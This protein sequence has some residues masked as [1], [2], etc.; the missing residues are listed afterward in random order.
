MRAPLSSCQVLEKETEGECF[1]G[2]E[3][4]WGWEETTLGRETDV[5]LEWH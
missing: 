5:E 4:P 3:C 1:Q 2:Q